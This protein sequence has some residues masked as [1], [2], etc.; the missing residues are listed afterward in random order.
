MAA[1]PVDPVAAG[2]FVEPDV[3]EEDM[4]WNSTPDQVSFQGDKG[5]VAVAATG[6]GFEVAGRQVQA[7]DHLGELALGFGGGQDQ[8]VGALKT[9]AGCLPGQDM[10]LGLE[11]RPIPGFIRGQAQEGGVEA[12]ETQPFGQAAQGLIHQEFHFFIDRETLN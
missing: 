1:G 11:G 6:Q 9:L 7:P 12:A 2:T 4:L 3:G 8:E 10:G 5:V